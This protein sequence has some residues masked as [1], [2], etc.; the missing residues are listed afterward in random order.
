MALP[1]NNRQR[2]IAREASFE[3]LGLFSGERA[4][5]TFAPAGPDSGITF[6]RE[7]DGKVATIPALVANVLKRPRRTCLRNGTLF[8]ETIEHCMAALAGMGVHNAVVRVAGGHV[9][10]LPG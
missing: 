1:V 4:R 9:G 7:Q 6:V 5:L 2:T 8:V 3:G 10:E